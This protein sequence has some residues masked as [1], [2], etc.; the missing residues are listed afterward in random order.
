MPLQ[1]TRRK[2]D[3]YLEA[4]NETM[5]AEPKLLDLI[6]FARD[7]MLRD[8]SLHRPD[9]S[10]LRFTQRDVTDSEKDNPNPMLQHE[11]GALGAAMLDEAFLCLGDGAQEKVD[12]LRSDPQGNIIEVINW[13]TQRIEAI[14]ENALLDFKDEDQ[15]YNYQPY[16]LSPKMIGIYPEV[17]VN[18]TCL[19]KSILV[20]AFFKK[21]DIPMLHAGILL[22]S[23]ET[24]ME[25]QLILID[26]LHK[27]SEAGRIDTVPSISRASEYILR[28]MI[29]HRG[30]HA[31]VYAKTGDAWAQVDINYRLNGI[32][33]SPRYTRSMDR[34]YEMTLSEDSETVYSPRIA[35]GHESIL[36]DV[37]ECLISNPEG[38]FDIDQTLLEE[39]IL[40]GGPKEEVYS[41]ILH[42]I[43]SPFLQQEYIGEDADLSNLKGSQLDIHILLSL[44]K[45][46]FADL[47]DLMH[48][49]IGEFAFS[50]SSQEF[51]DG[52]EVA[53]Q[54]M[55]PLLAR[56]YTDSQY[57][58]D[59]IKDL[60]LAPYVLMLKIVSHFGNIDSHNHILHHSIEVAQPEYRIGITALSDIAAYYGDELPLSMWFKYWTS[61]MCVAEH[62]DRANSPAQKMIAR[63]AITRLFDEKNRLLTNPYARTIMLCSLVNLRN[64]E[65]DGEDRRSTA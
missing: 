29:N 38:I 45:M 10:E 13:L 24:V 34:L 62:I 37:T 4:Q 57:R 46:T 40:S 23:H 55:T 28:K 52:S 53:P 8:P 63:T 15:Q 6:D 43:F 54:D 65:D 41:R 12:L 64:G 49:T 22:T 61:D 11:I 58:K 31:A 5:D 9:R 42:Y 36:R 59:R 16:R 7:L 21:V 44:A 32:S 50:T 25:L 47:Q 33:T 48:E 3:L 30:F 20:A 18:P 26:H 27:L 1:E 17:K 56:L 60:T 35:A 14:E 51:S 39:I 19:G 2:D